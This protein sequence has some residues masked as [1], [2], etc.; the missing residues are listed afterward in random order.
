M[1]KYDNL[2]KDASA[3]KIILLEFLDFLRFKISN[4]L[5]TMEEVEGMA[6]MV[7][8]SL[9]MVGT[10]EDFARFYNQPKTNVT[11]MINRR[12]V[13]KP[14]RRVLYSF[15]VFRRLVPASWRKNHP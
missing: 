11:S 13:Q 14:V 12:M 7:E 3:G 10:S 6:R 8:E 1:Q 2:R 4:D 9:P 15:N 5:L